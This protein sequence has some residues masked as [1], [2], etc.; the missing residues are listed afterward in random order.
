M[1]THNQSTDQ[2]TEY[3]PVALAVVGVV[4]IVVGL[5][6]TFFTGQLISFL[7]FGLV[8]LFFV[9]GG[10]LF[11]SVALISARPE[12]PLYTWLLYAL[13]A[14]VVLVAVFVI[15]VLQMA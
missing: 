12:N 1:A 8:E 13:L 5:V 14:V 7:G 6:T 9:A 3:L 10:A 15:W 11:V 2:R 4:S